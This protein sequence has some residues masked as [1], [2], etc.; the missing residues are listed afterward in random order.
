MADSSQS[1]RPKKDEKR[2][3]VRTIR[4]IIETV[5]NALLRDLKILGALSYV[6]LCLIGMLYARSFYDTFDIDIFNF[7]EPLDF[8]FVVFSK[9]DTLGR[10]LLGI[11]LVVGGIII[12]LH[13]LIAILSFT[14]FII[15]LPPLLLSFSSHSWLLPL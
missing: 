5:K 12:S 14:A 8:L 2:G 1:E 15:L 9:G 3:I 4:G 10:S 6:W 13:I 11:L 7:A